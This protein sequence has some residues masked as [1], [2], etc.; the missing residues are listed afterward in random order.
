[1]AT[2]NLIVDSGA[3]DENAGDSYQYGKMAIAIASVKKENVKVEKLTT[4]QFS[5]IWF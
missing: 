3:I 5:R 2:A 4:Y 1:M